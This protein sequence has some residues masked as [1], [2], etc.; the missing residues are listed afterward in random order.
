MLSH[1]DGEWS[2][3]RWSSL[4]IALPNLVDRLRASGYKHSLELE[5]QLEPEFAEIDPKDDLDA[6]FP[7]FREKGRVT[8]LE[9]TSRRIIYCSRG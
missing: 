9:K 4:D 7:C 6:I 1:S 8:L 3:P 5:F 2:Y